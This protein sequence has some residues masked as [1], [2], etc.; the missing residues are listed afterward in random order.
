MRYFYAQINGASRCTG[1]IDTHKPIEAPHMIPVE[2]IDVTL[3]GRYWNGST[4]QDTPIE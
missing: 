3:L 4:W 1:V 2:A